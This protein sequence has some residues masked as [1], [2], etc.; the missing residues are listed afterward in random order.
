MENTQQTLEMANEITGMLGAAL[1][2]FESGMTLGVV[3]TGIDLEIAC[4]G[5]ME[6]MRAKTRVMTQLG[7]KG[8]IEDILIT[9]E[10]Q[11]HLLRPVGP[12]LFLYLALQRKNAN[13]AMARRQLGNIAA[14]L[15]VD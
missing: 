7:I 15:H 12:M 1:V 14:E 10:S 8:G 4:A 11:Y 13:L 6:V 5:N 3:G 9:L 2:D